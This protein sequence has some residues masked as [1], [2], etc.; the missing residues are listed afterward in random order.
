MHPKVLIITL[1]FPP[2]HDQMTRPDNYYYYYCYEMTQRQYVYRGV[3]L[4][5]RT[6]KATPL[7]RRAPSV[8]RGV[9]IMGHIS[10]IH[11]YAYRY[12]QICCYCRMCFPTSTRTTYGHWL[13]LATVGA[14]AFVCGRARQCVYFEVLVH[15]L[16]EELQCGL[17]P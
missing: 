4:I 15:V 7:S 12:I 6:M 16:V 2:H 8:F 5:E 13:L 10:V 11:S 1:S 14:N 17:P 9:P 3:H